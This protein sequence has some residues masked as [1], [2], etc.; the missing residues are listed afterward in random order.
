VGL[1]G[2]VLGARA[3]ESLLYGVD[4]FDGATLAGTSLLMLVVAMLASWIPA[5][6][7]SSVD[8]VETLAE[9]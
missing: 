9:S 3:L 7:A 5:Y 2:A 4:A 8:P 6:R 1:I